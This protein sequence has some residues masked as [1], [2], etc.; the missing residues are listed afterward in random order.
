MYEHVI[1]RGFQ[2]HEGFPSQL[3]G[4]KKHGKSQETMDDNWGYPHD[5]GNLQITSNNY[6]ESSYS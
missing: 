1:N 3:D 6:T 2:S 4:K 5:L